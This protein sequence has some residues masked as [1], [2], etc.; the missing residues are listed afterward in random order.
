MDLCVL[1]KEQG[2]LLLLL[3]LYQSLIMCTYQAFYSF[4]LFCY[5]LRLII[6]LIQFSTYFCD[7]VTAK[8][9]H[10]LKL[11]ISHM[12][13]FVCLFFFTRFS[14]VSCLTSWSMLQQCVKNSPQFRQH[15]FT[16]NQASYEPLCA[17]VCVVYPW[18]VNML[19]C[20][21]SMLT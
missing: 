10:I 17:D 16:L 3:L 1:L 4:V 19:T 12:L 13:Q 21:I 11:L 14:R 8:C 2:L 7:S 6:I 5:L 9:L 20:E 18:Q 15:T